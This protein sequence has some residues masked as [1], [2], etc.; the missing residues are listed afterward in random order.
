MFPGIWP[1]LRLIVGKGLFNN[2][3]AVRRGDL[4]AV[5]R[6]RLEI[7]KLGEPMNTTIV[8]EYRAR[9]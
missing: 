4:C 3:P 8:A 7:C 5:F 2:V 1:D 6:D 9:Q